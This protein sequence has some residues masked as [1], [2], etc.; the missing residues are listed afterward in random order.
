[1][2]T[3]VIPII[4]I[5]RCKILKIQMPEGLEEGKTQRPKVSIG[6][7]PSYFKD[8]EDEPMDIDEDIDN[9]E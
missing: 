8:L 1:M 4:Q 2:I 7:K 9:D 6:L 5:A 3:I